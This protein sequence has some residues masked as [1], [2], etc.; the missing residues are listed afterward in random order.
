[1][2]RQYCTS[3]GQEDLKEMYFL[4]VE[5]LFK[6]AMACIDQN[7]HNI[8]SP[9]LRQ[10]LQQLWQI[11][12]AVMDSN[13]TSQISKESVFVVP[14]ETTESVTKISSVTAGRVGRKLKGNLP[15]FHPK[16]KKLN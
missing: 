8:I 11:R 15:H 6:L 13:S 16:N 12:K 7:K 2:L 1:M 4:F 3:K 9:S 10:I 14:P 5:P